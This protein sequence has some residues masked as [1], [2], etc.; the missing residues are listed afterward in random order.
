V[1][2]ATLERDNPD[3]RDLF[4]ALGAT[5]AGGTLDLSGA[6]DLVLF[7]GGP[8]DEQSSRA[9]RNLLAASYPAEKLS[10]YRG[11]MQDWMILGLPAI[12]PGEAG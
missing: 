3:L 9:I 6:M 8:W 5:D 10:W 12:V 1:P 7:C 2:F 11:G 4:L